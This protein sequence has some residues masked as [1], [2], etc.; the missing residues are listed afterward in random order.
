MSLE[1]GDHNVFRA[2]LHSYNRLCGECYR[3]AVDRASDRAAQLLED[4]DRGD[5]RAQ[6]EFENT[7]EIIDANREAGREG[8]FGV[9]EDH[10]VKTIACMFDGGIDR[11]SALRQP[12]EAFRNRPTHVSSTVPPGV[13]DPAFI[14]AGN[15]YDVDHIHDECNP[16]TGVKEILLYF[17]ECGHF[18]GVWCEE[19]MEQDGGFVTRCGCD[20][21][22]EKLARNQYAESA[23]LCLRCR[24]ARGPE[25]REMLSEMVRDVSGDRTLALWPFGQRRPY[26]EVR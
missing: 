9:N 7:Q 2:E 23:G 3:D 22:D 6:L 11:E 4:W 19:P 25:H 17:S 26:R 18:N 5:M 1:S 13:V 16:T 24:T 10:G 21:Y 12:R 15:A 8:P 20:R 14:S